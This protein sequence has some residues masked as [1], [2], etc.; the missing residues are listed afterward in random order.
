MADAISTKNRIIDELVEE[1][2]A[3]VDAYGTLSKW[4]R[5]NC[6]HES[7]RRLESS[8]CL[9]KRVDPHSDLPSPATCRSARAA[10]EDA[11]AQ[12]K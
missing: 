3:A 9:I 8:T 4:I 11:K 2:D 6:V 5:K 7:C 1:R 10:L 12:I